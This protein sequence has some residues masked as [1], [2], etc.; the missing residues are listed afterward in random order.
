MVSALNKGVV[1]VGFLLPLG[2][3]QTKNHK[4]NL[5]RTKSRFF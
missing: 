1:L 4:Q 5:I 3:G 2:L